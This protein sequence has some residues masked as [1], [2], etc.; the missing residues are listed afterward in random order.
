M[1]AAVETSGSVYVVYDNYPVTKGHV[2]AIPMRHVRDFFE[3]TLAERDHVGILFSRMRHL[4]EKGDPT[5]TG[6]N[7]GINCGLSA[8]QTIFHAHFHMIPRRDGD[9][10]DPRGGI[11]GCVPDKMHY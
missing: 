1:A 6:W 4:L 10:P 7:I 11:R 8:G 5:I 9:C 3:L 2:L